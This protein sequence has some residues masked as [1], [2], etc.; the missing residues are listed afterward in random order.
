MTL[1]VQEILDNEIKRLP[2]I[3]TETNYYTVSGDDKFLYADNIKI[4][5]DFDRSL[6]ENLQDLYDKIILEELQGQ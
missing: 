2:I 1:K 5:Y 4:E 3:E 6:D